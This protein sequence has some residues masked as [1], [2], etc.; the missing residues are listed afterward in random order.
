MADAEES[1]WSHW[2][3]RDEQ[4]DLPADSTDAPKAS[5]WRERRQ[6]E[7][8][9]RAELMAAAIESG[10]LTVRF[11]TGA[12]LEALRAARRVDPDPVTE[13]APPVEVPVPP[14][15]KPAAPKPTPR[16]LVAPKP[17]VTATDATGT[18]CPICG[19]TFRPNK[20]GQV[21]CGVAC[22]NRYRARTPRKAALVTLVCEQ[23]GGTFEVTKKRANGRQYCSRACANTARFAAAR[24]AEAA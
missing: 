5:N 11:A 22:S 3:W 7:R 16:P 2:R 21:C 6:L 24:T 15:P 13:P 17:L 1:R 19:T 4:P 20:P 14:K 18:T 9:R 23:C 12:E 8:D 10:R